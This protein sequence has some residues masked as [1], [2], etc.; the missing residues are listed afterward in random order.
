V[1]IAQF[2]RRQW[3]T[4]AVIGVILSVV[5]GQAV[6]H[7]LDQPTAQGL[8]I[9]GKA[10][11]FSLLNSNGNPVTLGDSAG[12]VRLVAF[13]YTRCNSSC[14]VVTSQ[15]V[16]LENELKRKGVFGNAVEF[17]TVTMDP[18]HDTGSVLRDYENRFGVAPNGWEFLTGTQKAIDETMKKYGVYAQKISASQYI[19]TAAEFLIDPQGNIRK[20]YG[21]EISVPDAVKDIESLLQRQG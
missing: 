19:H 21:A 6:L 15:M 18:S 13:I 11:N 20:I 2:V 1:N 7:D 3:A 17:I 12:K 4:L 16:Q 9:E 14:P 8:P 5:G 10:Y